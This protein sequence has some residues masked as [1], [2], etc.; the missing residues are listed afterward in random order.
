VSGNYYI[1]RPIDHFARRTNLRRREKGFPMSAEFESGV[2]M[3][4]LAAWHGLGTVV[5]AGHVAERDAKAALVE[6]GLD[7]EVEMLPV[8]VGN[9]LVPGVR[10]IQRKSDQK[11]LGNAGDVPR[12]EG[13]ARSTYVP[14]QNRDMAEWVQPILDAGLG[15]ID[16]TAGL[17]GGQRVYMLVKLG[18]NGDSRA[19]IVEGDSIVNH[20]LIANS[21][22]GGHSLRVSRCRTRV[23]CANTLA[24]AFGEG[25]NVRIRH[26]KS[27]VPVLDDLQK[28]M[29]REQNSFV[30]DADIFRSLAKQSITK[31]KLREYIEATFPESFK[32]KKETAASIKAKEAEEKRRAWAMKNAGKNLLADI[33]GES[34]PAP[35]VE[36]TTEGVALVSEI[37]GRVEE[38][39]ETGRGAEIPG[40]RGTM[41][42]AYNAVVEYLQYEHGR[43]PK[44]AT[45]KRMDAL[46]FGAPATWNALALQNAI[47]FGKIGS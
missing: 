3:R 37:L 26:T 18:H 25:T 11:I 41:W 27:M 34:E 29:L 16:A 10:V 23:V 6:G 15:K 33:M 21:H 42:G 40:V 44:G 14:Y 5:E 46:Q 8:H 38:L 45:D 43:G 24:A 20:W 39:V 7:W 1:A 30:K 22:D 17:Y 12:G 32:D 47:A 28:V 4:G 19:D 36:V 9:Q 31:K 35:A 13:R 2:F